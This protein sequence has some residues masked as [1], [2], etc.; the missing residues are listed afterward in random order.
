V[1]E[2]ERQAGKTGAEQGVVEE[3]GLYNLF[4]HVGNVYIYL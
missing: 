2:R 3:S 4:T 1:G